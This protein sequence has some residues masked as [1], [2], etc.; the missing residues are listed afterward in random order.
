MCVENRLQIYIRGKNLNWSLFILYASCKKGLTFEYIIFI[1]AHIRSVLFCIWWKGAV[2]IQWCVD[3]LRVATLSPPPQWIV[4]QFWLCLKSASRSFTHHKFRFYV[5]LRNV[6]NGAKW[7]YQWGMG[8]CVRVWYGCGGEWI[9]FYI[10]SKERDICF[11]T[12][13]FFF[14]FWPSAKILRGNFS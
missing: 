5:Y 2:C 9:W 6:C 7:A 1:Y 8:G 14:Y 3:A 13:K 11:L 4:R 12:I 10:F